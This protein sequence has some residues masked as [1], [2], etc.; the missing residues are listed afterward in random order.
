[1][2]LSILFPKDGSIRPIF[3]VGRNVIKN[4]R[5][6][7]FLALLAYQ[8]IRD[9]DNGWVS[10]EDVNRLIAYRKLSVKNTG[11]YLVDSVR[12]QSPQF[13]RF[14]KRCIDLSSNNYLCLFL[15][16]DRI[17]TDLPLL[18]KY[19]KWISCKP[20]LKRKN[21]DLLWDTACNQLNRYELTGCQTILRGL[22][23]DCNCGVERSVI[24]LL[25]IAAIERYCDYKIIDPARCVDLAATLLDGIR[26]KSKQNLYRSM[27]L[28]QHAMLKKLDK[29]NSIAVR[30]LNKMAIEQIES[31]K[32]S[33]PNIF[34]ILGG[35][36]FQNYYLDIR[37][38]LDGDSDKNFGRA[39]KFYRRMEED[40]DPD[41]ALYTKGSKEG[42]QFQR[43]IM[44]SLMKKQR[45]SIEEESWYKELVD[46]ETVSKYFSLI[47]GHWV[48]TGMVRSNE[49]IRA[50]EFTEVCLL[51]HAELHEFSLFRNMKNDHLKMKGK[52]G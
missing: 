46:S 9:I 8:R 20:K 50:S 2:T 21:A 38:G 26:S 28:T 40:G 30:E 1:M 3:L 13:Q 27:I 14:I 41:I 23:D 36:Y 34:S 11:K 25:R 43:Q 42:I 29:Q 7:Q 22:L 19:L 12:Y 24:A 5:W 44:I 15:E 10:V 51:E 48:R 39:K 6:Q 47:L 31:D 37:F 32:N 35:R 45:I 33:N 16:A 49:L 4:N 17:I 18:E 52:L